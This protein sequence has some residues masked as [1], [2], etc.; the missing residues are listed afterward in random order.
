MKSCM[1]DDSRVKSWGPRVCDSSF[2]VFNGNSVAFCHNPSHKNEAF[3]QETSCKAIR[4][5]TVYESSCKTLTEAEIS[6]NVSREAEHI[7]GL[8]TDEPSYHTR[9]ELL[10]STM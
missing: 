7:S 2:Q 5:V 10:K 6:R 4:H 8:P 3:N 9:S 1:R